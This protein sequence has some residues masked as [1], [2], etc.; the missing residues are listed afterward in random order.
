MRL[1]AFMITYLFFL[2]LKGN[3]QRVIELNIKPPEFAFLNVETQIGIGTPKARYGLLL[4]YRPSTQDSGLAKSVGTGAADGYGH[5]V[6]NRLCRAYTAGLYNKTNISKTL[7]TFLETDIF[8]RNR[9]FDKKQAEYHNA[10]KTAQDFNGIRTENVDVYCLKLL[11]GKTRLFKPT[12][13]KKTKLYV[14][15]YI[16][17]GIRY[18]EET[19]ETFNG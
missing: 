18:Q 4:S 16:G 6:A 3:S 1:A 17:A 19:Y 15:A 14:D 7:T 11:L 10:E 12:K 13:E 5:G 9:H 2:S 8:Y